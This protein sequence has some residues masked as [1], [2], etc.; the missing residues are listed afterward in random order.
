MR[1]MTRLSLAVVLAAAPAGAQGGCLRQSGNG[2]DRVA[3][4]IE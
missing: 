2:A 4:R 3:G 1:I